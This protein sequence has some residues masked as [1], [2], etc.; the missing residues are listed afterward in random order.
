MSPTPTKLKPR[1]QS[2]EIA[3]LKDII[4]QQ[5]EACRQQNER[6]AV[7]EKRLA[8]VLPGSTTDHSTTTGPKTND[9]TDLTDPTHDL[10]HDTAE[11]LLV[12]AEPDKPE[13]TAEQALIRTLT[14]LANTVVANSQP[15]KPKEKSRIVKKG[16]KLVEFSKQVAVTKCFEE[17][18]D[19]FLRQ[20]QPSALSEAETLPLLE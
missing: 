13:P 7:L 14:V 8:A 12:D 1:D 20:M 10:Q 4:R 3:A 6:L 18:Y 9:L 11:E 15:S 17:W 5:Q 16:V 19:D 2:E